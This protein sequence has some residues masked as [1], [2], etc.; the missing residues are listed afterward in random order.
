[1]FCGWVSVNQQNWKGQKMENE[2][3]DQSFG[4][5]VAKALD[6]VMN[7]GGKK[8]VG[9]AVFW[10]EFGK[11]EGGRVNYVSNAQREDML[12]AVREWLAR[13]EGRVQTPDTKQ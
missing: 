12:V 7:P 3:V 2:K 11:T 6:K 10:F 4:Q 8:N 1:M 9:F 5:V 13:A